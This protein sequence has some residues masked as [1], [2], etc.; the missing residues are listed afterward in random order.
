MLFTQ[1]GEAFVAAARPPD[2][3]LAELTHDHTMEHIVDRLEALAILTL[4]LTCPH[5][6]RLHPTL[7]HSDNIGALSA[8]VYGYA[9]RTHLAQITNLTL[10]Y[11]H[12]LSHQVRYDYVPSADNSIDMPTRM[13]MPEVLR[14]AVFSERRVTV[15]ELVFPSQTIW[16]EP[17]LVITSDLV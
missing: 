16:H 2:W 4:H 15:L 8:V 12:M 14:H 7:V 6:M 13:E 10:L 5:I 1:D 17:A 9:S 11:A 3:I